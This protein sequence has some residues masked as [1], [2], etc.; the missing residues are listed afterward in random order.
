MTKKGKI[1]VVCAPSGA[2]KST[3]CTQIRKLTPSLSYSVSYTTRAARKGEE[4]GSDY[5]FVTI[6]EF[7]K[8]IKEDQWAEWAKVHDNYYGT[9]KK[10]LED[11]LIKGLNILLEI[12]V[13]GAKQIK[14]K[15]PEAVSI[16]ILPPSFDELRNRLEKR[17]T[18]TK[19]VIEKRLKAAKGEIAQSKDFDYQVINDDF[20][21]AAKELMDIMNN[22]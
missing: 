18:E 12:D 19:E 16:F 9:S 15:I 2:G 7:K 3:L 11:A 17:G 22:E 10:Y 13:Q 6:E 1:F 14:E 8:G 20:D 4:D 21:T 5:F